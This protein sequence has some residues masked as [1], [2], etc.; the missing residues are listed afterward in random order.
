MVCISHDLSYPGLGQR[1]RLPCFAAL[2]EL[3]DLRSL[4]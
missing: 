3:D 1:S 2:V 4:G